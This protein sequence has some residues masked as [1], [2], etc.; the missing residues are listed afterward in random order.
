MPDHIFLLLLL[1]WVNVCLS[2]AVLYI[3]WCGGW[4]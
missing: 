1:A 2:A 4:W 3:F